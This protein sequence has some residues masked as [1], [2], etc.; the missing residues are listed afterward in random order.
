MF[1]GGKRS[2][3]LESLLRI[4]QQRLDRWEIPSNEII[5]KELL[6]E[7]A[8]GEVYRGIIKCPIVSPKRWSSMNKSIF[9]PVA[10]KRLKRER[11]LNHIRAGH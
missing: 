1:S 9:T 8:F 10:I 11:I 2:L 3:H 4:S 6:G 5:V 7:G